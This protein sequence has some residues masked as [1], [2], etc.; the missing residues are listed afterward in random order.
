M[1]DGPTDDLTMD[2]AIGLLADS[3]RANLRDLQDSGM[4]YLPRRQLQ[5]TGSAAAQVQSGEHQKT[6]PSPSSAKSEKARPQADPRQDRKSASPHAAIPSEAGQQS[7]REEARTALADD[8]LTAERRLTIL[9][10]DIIGDCTDC[11]L[12][13]GRTNLVFGVGNPEARLLFVGEGP[14]AEEDRQGV[15]FVGKAGQLLT[16]MI[17]AMGYAREQVYICNVV[18]CR[19]PNNRD[20]E[21][22]E[23]EACN[24][25]MRSQLDI[26]APDVIVGLG[27]FACQTLLNTKTPIT[28]L[29][30]N[31]ASVKDGTGRAIPCMPTYHPA[32]LLRQPQRKREAWSDLQ[33]VMKRLKESV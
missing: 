25:F 24:A 18:K 21:P 19:P 1:S 9:A 29:R 23:V 30:G 4:L 31:W 11:K 12:H 27:R 26:V 28:R 33:Q 7:S 15:P 20:P 14:G 3:L 5:P 22:D 2:Q 8:A 16:K 10:E 17:E 6:G 13:R 32:F